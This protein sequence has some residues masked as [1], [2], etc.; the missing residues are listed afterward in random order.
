ME[1]KQYEYNKTLEVTE[2]IRTGLS[3]RRDET[4]VKKRR[5]GPRH[6]S[7]KT[8]IKVIVS[9]IYKTRETTVLKYQVIARIVEC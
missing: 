9:N 7:K 8:R 5:N 6:K 2:R 3:I 4:L 1:N